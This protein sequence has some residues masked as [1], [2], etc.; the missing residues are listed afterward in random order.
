MW[1]I[2]QVGADA[3]HLRCKITLGRFTFDAMAFRRGDRADAMTD[4]GTVDAVVTLDTG[5][6]GFVELKLEDFGA[7]G[8][9]DRMRSEMQVPA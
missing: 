5:M 2:R 4:A 8:T 7:A 3:D 6:R 1:G 9:A